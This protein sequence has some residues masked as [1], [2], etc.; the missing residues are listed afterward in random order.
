M[1]CLH[2]FWT[3][4]LPTSTASYGLKVLLTCLCLHGLTTDKSRQFK[5]QA[6]VGARVR[7]HLDSTTAEALR[8]TATQLGTSPFVLLQSLFSLLVSRYSNE[9]DVMMGARLQTR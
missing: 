7:Q 4:N 3:W 9:V 8:A 5:P 6:P 2:A 1:H